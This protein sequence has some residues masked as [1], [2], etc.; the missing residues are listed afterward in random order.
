MWWFF[1][2]NNTIYCGIKTEGMPH[3][4]TVEK[5]GRKIVYFVV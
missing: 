3:F 1:F 5:Y 2:E 4:A